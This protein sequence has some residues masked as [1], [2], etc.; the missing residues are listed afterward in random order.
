ME[1]TYPGWKGHLPTLGALGETPFHTIP[2][3][4]WGTVAKQSSLGYQGSP[5]CLVLMQIPPHCEH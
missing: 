3:K 4:T 2:F 5:P 1:K